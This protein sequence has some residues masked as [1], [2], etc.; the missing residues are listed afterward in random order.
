MLSSVE[1]LSATMHIGFTPVHSMRQT[2]RTDGQ[3][4][5]KRGEERSVNDLLL[6][7]MHII[8]HINIKFL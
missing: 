4:E 2:H 1:L 3:W 8:H 7:L 5:G 6:L